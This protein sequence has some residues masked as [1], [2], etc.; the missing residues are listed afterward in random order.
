MERYY[1]ECKQDKK[2]GHGYYKWVNG[3][4]YY[5]LYKDGMF[6]YWGEWKDHNQ[7]GYGTYKWVS[8]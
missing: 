4:E 7:E 1:G 3:N 2:D 5:G 6:S 8:G